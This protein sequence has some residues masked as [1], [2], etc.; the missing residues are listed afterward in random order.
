VGYGPVSLVTE[1][2]GIYLIT[3]FLQEDKN[4]HT[5]AL[6]QLLYRRGWYVYV[7]SAKRG[8]SSRIHRHLS[9]R[10]TCRWHIDY[11]SLA[12][13]SL[14]GYSSARTRAYPI[15]TDRDL[16]CELA[17]SV[18]DAGGAGVDQ[19]GSSDCS[20]KSHLF[21]FEKNPIQIP[22][23]VDMLFSYRHIYGLESFLQA[24]CRREH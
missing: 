2:R 21:R 13:D 20:C 16:E 18:Q 9:R 19:F 8:L 15:Y 22:A 7:G 3:L 23:F 6:G 11:L 24:I 10:K 5:G 1:D 17:R 4:V 12:A 14:R